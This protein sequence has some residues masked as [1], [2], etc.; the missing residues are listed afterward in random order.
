[1]HWYRHVIYCCTCVC[2]HAVKGVRAQVNADGIFRHA[3]S[4]WFH[5]ALEALVSSGVH[6][7]AIDVWVRPP[8][9]A[10][11]ST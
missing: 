2:Y 6:G 11:A 9:P 1:M 5:H 10:R 4:R 8:L 3:S 7:I